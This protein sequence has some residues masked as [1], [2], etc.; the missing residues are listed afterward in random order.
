VFWRE[1][2]LCFACRLSGFVEPRA[3]DGPV[4][5]LRG[6]FT[7]AHVHPPGIETVR[8]VGYR[9]REPE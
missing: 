4:A 1:E 8:G 2:L 6:K 5:G 7:A 3:V 9:F